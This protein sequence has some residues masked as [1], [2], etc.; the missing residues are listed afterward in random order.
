MKQEKEMV[1]YMNSGEFSDYNLVMQNVTKYY[2]DFLAVNQLCTAIKHS[3]CF[4]L[5]GVIYF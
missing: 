3:E 2:D 1:N 5:L 4:G